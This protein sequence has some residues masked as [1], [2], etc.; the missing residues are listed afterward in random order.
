MEDDGIFM[1]TWSILRSFVTIYAHLVQLVVIWYIS[2]RFGVPR[3]IWQPCTENVWKNQI[4]RK[5]MHENSTWI[6][7]AILLFL[8]DFLKAEM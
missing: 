8:L 5:E 7:V 3:K 1:D 2:S 6:N 4:P